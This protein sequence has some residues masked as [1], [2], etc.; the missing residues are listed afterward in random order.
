MSV[1]AAAGFEA[2]GVEAGL[3]SSGGL[4]VA[5]VVNRG[6]RF[7]AAAVF[8]SNRAQAHPIIWSKQAIDDGVVTAIALNSGGANCF[9][10]P[11]GFHVTH[12]TA[13]HVAE[14]LDISAGDILVC[15]TGLI[16]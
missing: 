15:S 9:T 13:E 6:P 10:G 3:K 16:G 2:A 12:A 14:I 1:T 7:D 4:D 8:T 11:Q 5:L